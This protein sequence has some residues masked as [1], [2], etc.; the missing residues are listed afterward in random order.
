MCQAPLAEMATRCQACGVEF[1]LICPDCEA[2]VAANAATCAQCGFVFNQEA[3]TTETSSAYVGPVAVALG[4]AA[5]TVSGGS[6][7]R[8]MQE[9]VLCPNCEAP[10]SLVEGFCRECGQTFCTRCNQA[11]DEEDE[12]CPHCQT[13]LFFDCPVCDFELTAGTEICPNCNTLFPNYCANCRQLL[14]PGD[15]F[16]LTCEARVMLIQ[17]KSAR[18]VHTIR[19]GERVV[20]IVACPEC[21][22]Q[23]NAG[24]SQCPRCSF[25]LC[26]NCQIHLEAGER[27]CPRCG[28]DPMQAATVAVG[29]YCPTCGQAIAA[30]SD[31]C[32]YCE[33]LLCPECLAAVSEEDTACPQ[34][35]IEF[36]LC[37]PECEAVVA[38]D[39]GICPY[40]GF[41]F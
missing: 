24:L 15:R 41:T 13:P 12:V 34:C 36:E 21:G 4:A 6:A 19:S 14:Q 33:Q 10:V 28:E 18:V 5:P 38:A 11:V 22:E 3:A 23:F 17:R 32:P 9:D 39:A 30:G 8:A 25:R 31:Q 1:D 35:G 29:P 2:V 37:C 40:C 7:P 27:V 16:C 26:P 20:Q